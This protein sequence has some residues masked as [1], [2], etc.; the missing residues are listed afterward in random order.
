[1]WGGNYGALT[2]AVRPHFDRIFVGYAENEVAEA[3]GH[4]V[5]TLRHPPLLMPFGM[6]LLRIVRFGLLFTTRGCSFGCTFCQT[7]A[8]AP[9]PST[10][11]RESI[12]RVLQCYAQH[13]V[14]DII[15]PDENFGIVP[16]HADEVT[17]LL[18][19]HRMLWTAMT[20]VDFLLRHFDQWKSQ[21]LAGVMI[22]VESLDQQGLNALQKRSTMEKLYEAIELCRKHGIVTVG[23]YIVGLESDTEESIRA[24]IEELRTMRFDLVQMCVL[25]PLPQTPLWSRIED[26]YGIN[27]EDY[28]QFDGKHLVWNHPVLSKQQIENL[29]QWS[30]RMLYPRTNFARTIVKHSRAHAR[31][32]GRWRAAC[33]LIGNTLRLNLQPFRQLE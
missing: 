21:G 22:G 1:M 15:I 9:K 26:R 25:T 19:K 31:R 20:R 5:E 2:P 4:R 24:S 6:P 18:A 13:G 3:L 28:S 23:F 27:T 8:F 30:Y 29:L 33:H 16:H 11:P 17:A 32:V 10:I 7:P 12:Q 14:V